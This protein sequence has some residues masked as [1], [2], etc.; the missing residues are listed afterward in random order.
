MRGHPQHQANVLRR[1]RRFDG[2][3]CL[4]L[5]GT[6]SIALL[7][8]ATLPAGQE[9]AVRFLSPEP[10]STV[11]P[12]QLLTVRWTPLPPDTREFELLLLLDDSTGATVR[13]TIELDP[14]RR[15][16][17]WR[18]PNLPSSSARLQIRLSRGAG[19]ELGTMSAPFAISSS[20]STLLAGLTFHG[21]EWWLARTWGSSLAPIVPRRTRL[22][23]IIGSATPLEP[24]ESRWERDH[25]RTNHTEM[26]TGRTPGSGPRSHPRRRS[27][28]SRRPASIPQRE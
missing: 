9:P 10:A 18:I 3:R 6:L 12:G 1:R 16:Y 14:A 17:R 28:P 8:A 7:V 11:H 4:C 20:C 13:L 21:G 2:R 15:S 5:A 22:A 23:G 26:T 25:V 24:L 19:E 27:S